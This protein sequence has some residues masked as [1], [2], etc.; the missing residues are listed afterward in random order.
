VLLTI[1][2]THQPATELGFLLHK[3]PER[4]QGFE[5]PFGLAH[6]F[7]PQ[8][9][10]TCCTAALLLQ[11]DPIALVR[12]RRGPPGEG[13]A[14]HQ[15]V[16]DRPYVASSFLSVAISRVFGSALAGRSQS[17]AE[18]AQTPIPL[19]AGLSVVPSRS[20]EHL[21]HELFEPLGYQVHTAGH[22]L[23]PKFPAW[24]P[25][26]Y[27]RLTI[28]TTARLSQLLAHLYVLIPV[29]DDEKHYWIGQEEVEKLLR[30]GRG[31]IESHPLRELIA[32]RYL[33]HQ[34][35]LSERALA[36][37]PQLDSDLPPPA[38][39]E[40]EEELEA[41]ISGPRLDRPI[42]PPADGRHGPGGIEPAPTDAAS[43]NRLHDARMEAVRSEL[44]RA[45]AKSVI[46]LGC[47]EGKLL[48][49]LL[50]ESSLE[51]IAGMDVSAR[52]L[53]RA[54][55]RLDVDR[56]PVLQRGRIA[57]FQG[58]LVY[59]DARLVGFDAAALVEVI[60]HIDPA[61]L[62][63][64]ERVVFEFARPRLVIVTTP[65]REYNARFGSM[66]AGTVR[67]RDHRFEWSRG[68]LTQWALRIQER[69]GYS[70][71][72]ESIGPADPVLGPPTMMVVFTLS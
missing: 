10:S 68:E 34:R 60:E 6:V 64:A 53:A 63:T 33:K 12:E 28:R 67:H 2:T 48:Q 20:G 62:A 49:K 14:L 44:K 50:G 61:R 25:S 35:K 30:H 70:P 47:G 4:A 66:P 11:L 38:S 24:G 41:K 37:L 71:R 18:L 43:T 39:A 56:L 16:N 51:R 22:P 65:N 58:S 55:L 15:Y 1:T 21:L 7:Y 42:P 9:T 46:D 31:W 27:F 72:L 32:Q 8:A 26:S 45:A 69:F 5:L 36:V 17:C 29:L 54:K 59:R 40:E 57:L 19:E 23:D 3:H 13:F 52:S